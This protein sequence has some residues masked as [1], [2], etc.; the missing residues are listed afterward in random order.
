MIRRRASGTTGGGLAG[1]PLRRIAR[2]A[3]AI[4]ANP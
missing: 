4:T 1:R 3:H 2:P